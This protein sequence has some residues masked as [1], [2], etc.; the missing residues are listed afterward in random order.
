MATRFKITIQVE[1]V[2]PE[3]WL[4]SQVSTL[5]DRLGSLVQTT[6]K[7]AAPDMIA[8][9]PKVTWSMPEDAGPGYN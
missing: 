4:P 2:M 5:A 7:L 8:V 3:R 6:L 9:T 1:M